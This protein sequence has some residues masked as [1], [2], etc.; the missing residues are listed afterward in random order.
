MKRRWVMSVAVVGGVITVFANGCSSA[1]TTFNPCPDPSAPLVCPD[2]GCCPA[3]TPY[4][5]NGKCYSSPTPCGSSYVTCTAYGSSSNG[6]GGVCPSG[7]S[8]CGTSHCAP[9]GSVC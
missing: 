1:L 3:D 2:H 5:C 8:P 4:Q 6:S 7:T 9:I